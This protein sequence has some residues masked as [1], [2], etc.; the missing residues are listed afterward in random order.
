MM[1]YEQGR[2]FRK[3]ILTV[4]ISNLMADFSAYQILYPKDVTEAW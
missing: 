3:I 1:L 4:F 2:D